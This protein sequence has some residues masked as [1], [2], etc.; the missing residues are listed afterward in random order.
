[1]KPKQVRA[2]YE[3]HAARIERWLDLALYTPSG[4]APTG[5]IPRKVN[6]DLPRSLR[7]FILLRHLVRLESVADLSRSR[8][9]LDIG[10][11]F[12]DFGIITPPHLLSLHA[13]DPGSS[14]ARFIRDHCPKYH[15]VYQRGMEKVQ[16]GPYDTVVISR[17]WQPDVVHNLTR[18]ILKHRNIRDVIMVQNT[19][20]EARVPE[21]NPALASGA[22]NYNVERPLIRY[23]WPMVDR[24]FHDHGFRLRRQHSL[25]RGTDLTRVWSHHRRP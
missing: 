25:D 8:R 16:M 11:G 23:T 4:P 7:R 24:V 22:W 18:H 9:V 2:F 1:M 3:R 21:R 13:C 6:R 5:D 15:R 20:T 14:Q 19:L 12:G 10:A 17:V